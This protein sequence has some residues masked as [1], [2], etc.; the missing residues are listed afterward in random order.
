MSVLLTSNFFANARGLTL[1]DGGGITW[2]I[3]PNTNAITATGSGGGV[4]SSVGL[5]DAS[6]TPIFT[7]GNSPLTANGALT[8]TLNTQ[9]AHTALMGPSS[10]ANAQPTFRLL[11]A[12]DIPTIPYTGV[13]GLATVAHTGAYSDLSGTPSLPVG[14]NPS[15]SVG[16]LVVNGSAATWMR[17]DGA[18]ALSQAIIPTWSGLHTFGAGLTVSAGTTTISGHTL[19]LSANATIGGTNTGDQTLPVG[20]NP[21]ATIGLSVINGSAATWMRSDGAPA[22]SQ[23]IVPTWSGTHTFTAAIVVQGDST[24]FAL[25]NTAAANVF[26]ITTPVGWAGFGSNTDAALGSFGALNFYVNDGSN[27][28]LVIATTGAATFASTFAINNGTPTAQLTGFGSP[29]G[30]VTSGLTGG[31]TAT[32]VAGT[33]AALLAYLKSIGFIGA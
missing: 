3:N 25:K 32:Q 14:A 26:R 30:A 21:S 23:A 33:L 1:L 7:V 22:I 9:A 19:V 18:P 8:L 10:G 12:G 2:S 6:G 17:S 20:A 13:S 4:L 15:A 31:S 29:S 27:P 5:S 16:L 28:T 11:V 24:V